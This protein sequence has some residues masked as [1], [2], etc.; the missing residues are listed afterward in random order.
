MTGSSPA[1][2]GGTAVPADTGPHLLHAGDSVRLAEEFPGFGDSQPCRVAEEAAAD[3]PVMR[4]VGLEEERLAWGQDV[5]SAGAAG[6]P[7]VNLRHLRPVRQEA[8][9]LLSVTP[10]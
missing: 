6:L 7:E 3:Q 1:P 5:E 4:V 10:T 2:I 8:Y 9:Q